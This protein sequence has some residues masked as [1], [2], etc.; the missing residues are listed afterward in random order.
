MKFLVSI[1]KE[2]A[3]EDSKWTTRREPVVPCFPSQSSGAFLTVPGFELAEKAEVA[4]TDADADEMALAMAK[5]YPGLPRTLHENYIMAVWKAVFDAQPGTVFTVTVNQRQAMLVNA[6]TRETTVLWR[7]Q[8][9]SP[10]SELVP[11]GK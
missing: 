10:A 6:E 5:E 11:G 7:E 4:E 3:T 9:L 2:R 8:P 1:P